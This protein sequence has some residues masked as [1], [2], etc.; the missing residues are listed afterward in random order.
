MNKKTEHTDDGDDAE[1][2]WA[3]LV[4]LV[5]ATRGDWRR[6]VTEA[7]GLAFSR[8]RALWR[9]E[10]QPRTLSE[11]AASMSIDAP[12]ATVIINDLE[13]RGLVQRHEIP[14]NR[15]AKRVSL[16][17]AG[18]KLLAVVDAIG[19]PPPDAIA[20]LPASQLAQLRRRLEAG[21][22]KKN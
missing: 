2:V 16:T 6:Q 7:T 21:A 10:E 22:T 15:R 12:A 13:R 3:L 4:D 8:A 1:R 17:A 9:L 5:M 11:L 19:D 14:E 20:T 18:R